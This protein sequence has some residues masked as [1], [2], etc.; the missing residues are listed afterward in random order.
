TMIAT[1]K[2]T[3]NFITIDNLLTFLVYKNIK[4]HHNGRL[5]EV[6]CVKIRLFVGNFVNLTQKIT[7]YKS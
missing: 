3:K 1:T 5:F 4:I 6:N 2:I 7:W